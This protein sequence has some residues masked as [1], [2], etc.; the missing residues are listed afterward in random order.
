MRVAPARIIACRSVNDLMPP[1]AFTP[2]LGPTVVRINTMSSTVAPPVE[3]PVDVLTKSAPACLA[4]FHTR[5]FS[6][7]VNKQVSRITF[8]TLEPHACLM[9]LISSTIF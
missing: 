4:R 8:N 3:N 1:E 6:S 5:I 9:R 7:T 2:K